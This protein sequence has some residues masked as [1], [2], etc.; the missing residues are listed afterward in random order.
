MSRPSAC[1]NQTYDAADKNPKKILKTYYLCHLTCKAYSEVSMR[2]LLM[3]DVNHTQPSLVSL[4]S[5][6]MKN[7]PSLVNVKAEIFSEGRNDTLIE[8]IISRLIMEVAV[9]SANW[10]II[11]ESL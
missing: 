7:D 8:K 3:Q 2:M 10:Q 6:L 1:Q 5:N 11:E 4:S 9:L